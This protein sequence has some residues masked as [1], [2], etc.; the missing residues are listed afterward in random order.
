MAARLWTDMYLPSV[1][2]GYLSNQ[3]QT[4]AS[5]PV[6]CA[7]GRGSK[8]IPNKE[9]QHVQQL[10]AAY[11]ATEGAS[12]AAVTNTAAASSSS[13]QKSAIAAAAAAA[14]AA[15]GT[16]DGAEGDGGVSWAGEEY[17]PDRV[18]CMQGSYLKFMKRLGR[19]PQQ[20]ARYGVR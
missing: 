16:A 20:C 3:G 2:T 4:L 1:G 17:E 18:Q 13:S 11:E 9:L 7:D 19:Q 14:A 5:L 6:P 12:A 8:T 10:L 15:A